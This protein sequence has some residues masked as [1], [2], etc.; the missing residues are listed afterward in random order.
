MDI[1][2]AIYNK[3][4][5]RPSL[6]DVL[7][8]AI[9]V[10][11]ITFQPFYLHDEI[12]M[13]ETGL[14]LPGIYSVLHGGVPF[15]DFFHLRGPFEIYM[16]SGLM[17]L[18]GANVTILSLYFYI[19]TVLTL[20]I[21]IL[22]AKELYKTRYIL[23][24]MVPVFVA[25]TFPRVV[26]TRWG[27]M[28]FGF[29]LLAILCAVRFF[30]KGKLAWM[31][32]AGAASACAFFTSI[33]VGVASFVGVFAALFSSLFLSGAREKVKTA[34]GVYIAGIC[35][36]SIPYILY[37]IKINAFMP[38]VEAV[39]TVLTRMEYVFN[40]HLISNSPRNFI[41]ALPLTVQFSHSYFKHTTPFY[42]YFF[43][44]GYLFIAYKRKIL[45]RIDLGVICVAGY[46]LVMFT[47]AFRSIGSSQFEMAL[48]PEKI[49]LFFLLERAYFFIQQKKDVIKAG[50]KTGRHIKKRLAL[51]G[52]Y[53][54]LVGLLGSSIG[55][56]LSRYGKRFYSYR[57]L[58]HSI[59]GKDTQSLKPL[60]N[61]PMRP[62]NIERAK[63]MVVPV[64]QADELEEIVEW[65]KKYTQ[66]GE[67]VFTY[68]ELGTINFLADRPFVGRFPYVTF[69]WF[70]EEWHEELM[71]ELQNNMPRYAVVSKEM[72]P[73]KQVIYFSLAENKRKYDDVLAFL[74]K[75][76]ELKHS[77]QTYYFLE[78]KGYLFDGKT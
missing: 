18:A 61:I 49:L 52:I 37:L 67:I 47:S 28:R 76:Y 36:I 27:G 23:Y 10:I 39:F 77:T 40:P 24:L 48:Q 22:I 1:K 9:F 21:G 44:F 68:P 62:L 12:L 42:L 46:G 50:I 13:F 15:R 60:S 56:S 64:A 8:L 54:L 16:P 66:E 32:G 51:F 17:A 11:A 43:L 58:K 63:G 20:I 53:F 69:S 70:Q 2:S 3:F 59:L 7:I 38:Y 4:H 26:F 33:E 25:R 71:N 30:K 41:Q 31:F 74:N 57:L 34:F 29:G 75:N 5:Q 55:Y 73:E 72:M 35:L 78:R 19:G 45:S 14:Y 6:G 65:I